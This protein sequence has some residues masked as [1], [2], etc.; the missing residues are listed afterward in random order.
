MG[1]ESEQR[2][3]DESRLQG[4]IEARLATLEPDVEVL[5]VEKVGVGRSPGLR[6]FL[7]RSGGVD[8]ELCVRATRHLRDL[9][10]EYAIEVSSPG[11]A[12][13]LTRPAHYRRFLGR[14]VR[15]RTREA[16]EGRSEF[17]GELVG[18]DERGVAVEGDWGAVT[19]PH[20]R[21]RR[22][23]LVPEKD[24]VLGNT[25]TGRAK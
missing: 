4:E 5:L 7:D 20:D 22:S 9:L 19:I 14:R 16:I 18:A 3:P 15:V 10:R 24:G 1:Y 21:I 23:N 11:P 17:K 13:P 12:R 25:E 8:H 2:T 6:V